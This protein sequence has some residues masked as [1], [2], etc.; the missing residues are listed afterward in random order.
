MLHLALLCHN[1][2]R[3]I[4][5]C[6]IKKFSFP[7]N[8]IIFYISG[9]KKQPLAGESEGEV[10]PRENMLLGRVYNSI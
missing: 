7:I 2:V 1:A 9:L 10:S 3:S 8:I 4:Y 6:S 5:L